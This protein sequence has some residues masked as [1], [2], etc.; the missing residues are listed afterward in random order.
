MR[1]E[2][3]PLKVARELKANDSCRLAKTLLLGEGEDGGKRSDGLAVIFQKLN[4]LQQTVCPNIYVMKTKVKF[5][6]ERSFS[7]GFR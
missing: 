1:I 5:S 4:E 6:L 3:L 2:R 7:R